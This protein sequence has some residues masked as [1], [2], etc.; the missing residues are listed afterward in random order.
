MVW[1]WVVIFTI[2]NWWKGEVKN[3][4]LDTERPIKFSLDSETQQ[5]ALLPFRLLK[6]S[7]SKTPCSLRRNYY[8]RKVVK[9]EFEILWSISND[10]LC[11]CLCRFCGR[12]VPPSL[13]SSDN[14]MTLLFVSDISLNE[15]GFSASYVSMNATTGIQHICSFILYFR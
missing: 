8:V 12:S 1:D 7:N 13:T 14:Q 4:I 10:L 5:K 15:E 6:N 3:Q 2:W 9:V 11:F